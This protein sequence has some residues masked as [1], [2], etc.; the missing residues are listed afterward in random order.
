MNLEP[1]FIPGVITIMGLLL[2]V[3]GL[4]TFLSRTPR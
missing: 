4:A 2:A 1:L 3:L